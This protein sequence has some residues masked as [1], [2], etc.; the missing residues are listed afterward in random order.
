MS[1]AKDAEGGR[2]SFPDDGPMSS[3]QRAVH[4][5]IVSGPRGR[6]GAPF[7]AA[8]HNPD[9]AD[10]WQAL[11][12]V[13]RYETSLP[14]SLNELAILVTARR[15]NCDLE[16]AIHA[17]DAVAAGL[18]PPYVDAIRNGTAPG[19]GE[20][21]EAQEIYDFAWQVLQTG[22]ATDAAHAAIVQRW[23]ELGVV[24]LTALIGYYSMVAMT[25]TV[26]RVPIPPQFDDRLGRITDGLAEKPA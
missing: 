14:R 16:W 22:D 1:H 10:S 17:R 19:F 26:Q 2:I 11:G 18:P 4:D 8:L 24:E 7:R 5:R 9:L 13:L 23:G 6:L 15:W 12:R 3:A 25:L 21:S 20:D